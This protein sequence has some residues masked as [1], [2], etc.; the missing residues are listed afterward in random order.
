MDKE[1]TKEQNAIIA[2]RAL[3]DYYKEKLGCND[4]DELKHEAKLLINV[5]SLVQKYDKI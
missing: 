5:I 1:L 4:I 3:V 2:A